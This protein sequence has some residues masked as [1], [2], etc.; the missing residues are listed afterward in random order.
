MPVLVELKK[1]PD[2]LTGKRIEIA[3]IP[4]KC[5]SSNVRYPHIDWSSL[6]LISGKGKEGN[7]V[8]VEAM[9]NSGSTTKVENQEGRDEQIY[10]GDKFVGV[11]ANRYSGTSESGSV[12]EEGIDINEQTELHLLSTGAVIGINTE[13]H[14]E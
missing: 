2:R 4:I 6:Q 9:T 11:L 14:H 13:F 7:L 5:I 3:G 10:K 8:V 12:P 1:I